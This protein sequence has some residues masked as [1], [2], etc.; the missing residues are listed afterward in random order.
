MENLLNSCRLVPHREC[1]VDG[2]DQPV[3]DVNGT[4][5]I[6]FHELVKKLDK[7]IDPSLTH[8][9]ITTVFT[10]PSLMTSNHF[11]L[12]YLRVHGLLLQVVLSSK[13]E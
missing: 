11:C 8:S 6:Y 12:P 4:W 2:Q 1:K 10:P 13:D 9:Y 5:T 7:A 3:K